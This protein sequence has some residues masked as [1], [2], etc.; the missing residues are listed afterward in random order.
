M[1]PRRAV[2]THNFISDMTIRKR[3]FDWLKGPES[4]IF[5]VFLIISSFILLLEKLHLEH[6]ATISYK[7]VCVNMQDNYTID[8]SALPMA[9][10]LLR[11]EGYKLLMLM[12]STKSR[13]IEVDLSQIRPQMRNGLPHAMV[14]PRIYRKKIIESLPDGLKLE[15]VVSDTIFIPML[16]EERK[17]LQVKLSTPASLKAQHVFSAPTTITPKA[18]IVSGTNNILDTMSVVYTEKV[19]PIVLDDSLVVTYKLDLPKGV[20]SEFSEVTVRYYVEMLTQ[21]DIQVP[22]TAIGLP[23]GYKMK[24]FPQNVTM[25]F[26]VGMSNY[27]KADAKSF[28]IVA[29]MTN[30]SPGSDQRRVKLKLVHQ[31]DN[32]FNV[33]YSPI[34]VEYLLEKISSTNE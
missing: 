7:L 19:P 2:C 33:S 26:S 20:H 21:K 34:S 30:I 29:D 1:A 17:R 13:E 5:V 15:E 31:P 14:M 22:V 32:V 9:Q 6:K 8:E 28:D 11:G 4:R 16:K 10:V 24:A 25:S 23:D 27:E 18:V 3:F 12:S